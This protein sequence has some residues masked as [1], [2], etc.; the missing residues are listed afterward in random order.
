[1]FASYY[2]Y[3]FVKFGSEMVLQSKNLKEFQFLDKYFPI[4][5]SNIY[6]TFRINV[7]IIYTNGSIHYILFY[8]RWEI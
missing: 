7:N 8:F 3:S 1:M 6:T 2:S 5:C 4:A